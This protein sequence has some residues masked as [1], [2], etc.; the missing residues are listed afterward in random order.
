[1]E[2]RA[3]IEKLQAELVSP[4]ATPGRLK[5]IQ[6]SMLSAKGQ[7]MAMSEEKQRERALL[8]QLTY[9][10]MNPVCLVA[11][12]KIKRKELKREAREQFVGLPDTETLRD[13]PL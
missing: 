3:H 11:K 12:E 13:Q 4:S 10:M 2:T 1:M 6:E 9:D 8:G 7:G 5:P